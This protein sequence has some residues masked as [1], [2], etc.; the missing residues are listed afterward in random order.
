MK[1]YDIHID[2]DYADWIADIKSRHLFCAKNIEKQK[3]LVSIIGAEKMHQVGAELMTSKLHRCG[4]ELQFAINQ[5]VI[6]QAKSNWQSVYLLQKG[7]QET[8]RLVNKVDNIED[9]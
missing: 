8:K 9:K 5:G 3:Q 1:S 2:V 4:G 6:L 7:L